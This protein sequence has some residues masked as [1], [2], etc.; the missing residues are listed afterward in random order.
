M[1]GGGAT[2]NGGQTQLYV[3]TSDSFQQ[4][5]DQATGETI[6]IYD[7]QIEVPAG[8]TYYCFTVYPEQTGSG[9]L[10]IGPSSSSNGDVERLSLGG[11]I[12][13]VREDNNEDGSE[14]QA[15]EAWE[16]HGKG[17]PGGL[18]ERKLSFIEE[19]ASG[20]WQMEL[21][22]AGL[23]SLPTDRSYSAPGAA[24][25]Y[26][27]HGNFG[28]YPSPYAA[29]QGDELLKWP[30]ETAWEPFS[31]E[32]SDRAKVP[33]KPGTMYGKQSLT[34]KA[35][36]FGLETSMT[37][38]DKITIARLE[39]DGA[40]PADPGQPVS[41]T[42][43]TASTRNPFPKV[44][45]EM[46]ER[47]VEYID[48]NGEQNAKPIAVLKVTSAVWSGSGSL[49]ATFDA[50]ASSDADPG[51]TLT[52]EWDY[53]GNDGWTA[54]STSTSGQFTYSTGVYTPKLKV[55]DNHGAESIATFERIIVHAKPTD[56]EP[57]APAVVASPL[58]TPVQ[59]A[60]LTAPG[61][62][63]DVKLK[64]KTDVSAT[65][66]HAFVSLSGVRKECNT[67]EYFRMTADCSGYA[68]QIVYLQGAR[69]GTV[70]DDLTLI[71]AGKE[72]VESAKNSPGLHLELEATQADPDSEPFVCT[73]EERFWTTNAVIVD[74]AGQV[75]LSPFA[76]DILPQIEIMSPTEAVVMPNSTGLTITGQV[77][78]GV[79]ASNSDIAMWIN[80]VP[81]QTDGGLFT[82][83][84]PPATKDNEGFYTI[85]A[86]NGWGKQASLELK[87][88]IDNTASI[89]CPAIPQKSSEA[90]YFVHRGSENLTARNSTIV[91]GTNTSGEEIRGLLRFPNL[92]GNQPGQI[93]AGAT[94][95]AAKLR[96]SV[97]GDSSEA[98]RSVT[99]ARLADPLATGTW[100][101]PTAQT[102]MCGEPD[103]YGANVGVSWTRK[104]AT[105]EWASAGG[106]AP[107]SGL[108][109]I[110]SKKDAST[111]LELDVHDSVQAWAEGQPNMGWLIKADGSTISLY[112]GETTMQ[113]KVPV[114]V[115]QYRAP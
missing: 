5:Y 61:T 33:F 54:A 112:S 67:P 6:G 85:V 17:Q 25:P 45:G 93:P 28:K 87:V 113:G 114:L 100:Q 46:P 12:F 83:T 110:T 76:A 41:N 71:V 91:A 43:V 101:L 69:C 86:Q 3:Y 52:Y 68:S 27:A 80:D 11:G 90:A 47:L 29:D 13:F 111:V 74:T 57:E 60:L 103:E 38:P 34:A 98:S 50:S 108:A 75:G 82:Y 56:Q 26:M 70:T 62:T 48:V 55:K 20:D 30:G 37:F 19:G 92:I 66:G 2:F 106:D 8:A 84:G 36:A 73:D 109:T 78:S 24:E 31:N 104:H 1:F 9:W 18:V 63:I 42:N 77:H 44:I 49:N 72:L 97:A 4:V 15:V 32:V 23:K 58:G 14:E 94:I 64:V 88:L 102:G 59:V 22:V 7:F 16:S 39:V 99:F 10:T 107:E 53:L 81:V 35:R 79:Y 89:P 51:D 40:V 21:D 115:V 105:A 65:Q 95:V 96:V